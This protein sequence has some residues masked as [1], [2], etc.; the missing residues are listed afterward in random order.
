[1]GMCKTILCSWRRSSEKWLLWAHFPLPTWPEACHSRKSAFCCRE[2]GVGIPSTEGLF[3]EHWQQIWHCGKQTL[4]IFPQPFITKGEARSRIDDFICFMIIL[5]RIPQRNKPSARG[6]EGAAEWSSAASMENLHLHGWGKRQEQK[7]SKPQKTLMVCP[8][9]KYN[10]LVLLMSASKAPQHHTHSSQE[11]F[12]SF[13]WQLFGTV[14]LAGH[15]LSSCLSVC[16]HND[17]FL[18][19]TAEISLNHH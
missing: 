14:G 15:Q 3:I 19:Q 10:E 6:S 17:P 11:Q 7:Y 4:F 8:Q 18:R 2:P 16:K 1:M 9:T 12:Q 5:V 13:S